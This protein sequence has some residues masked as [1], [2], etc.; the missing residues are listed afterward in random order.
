VE[1]ARVRERVA[2]LTPADLAVGAQINAMIPAQLHDAASQQGTAAP[3]VLAMLLDRRPDVGA[4]QMEIIGRRLRPSV[5]EQA[6]RFYP[7]AAGL[8]PIVR[9]PIV[10]IAAPL[11]AARPAQDR[12]EL[13]IALDELARADG[14][15]TVFEYSLTRLVGAHLADAGDPGPRSRPGKAQVRG[16]REAALTL[17]ACVSAAGN[18]DPAAAEHAFQ[19]AAAHLLPGATVPYAPPAEPWR[20]LDAGWEPLNSL[21]PRNKQVLVEALVIAVADDGVLQPAEAELLRTACAM[22]RC[23]LPPLLA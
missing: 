5:A 9:M 18:P 13:T 14:Q 23:P 12:Q 11:L 21:D 10:S 3:L 19:A 1:P 22:L 2:S 7:E 15:I 4:A 16:V 6:A 17:L 20:A 8:D